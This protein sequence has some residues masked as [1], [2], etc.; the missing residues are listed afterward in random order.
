MVPF[1]RQRPV[2]AHWSW[3][4]PSATA[5]EVTHTITLS[6]FEETIRQS[7]KNFLEWSGNIAIK[8]GGRGQDISTYTAN[9]LKDTTYGNQ[10]MMETDEEQADGTWIDIIFKSI[11]FTIS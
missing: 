11:V 7:G 6:N 5:S 9:I 1:G 4:S 2:S 8:I 3:S 10:N